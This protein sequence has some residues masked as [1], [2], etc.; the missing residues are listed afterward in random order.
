MFNQIQLFV[1]LL[2]NEIHVTLAMTGPA[3]FEILCISNRQ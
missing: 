2:V 3:A 1:Q